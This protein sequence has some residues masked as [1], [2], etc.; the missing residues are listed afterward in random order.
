[1]AKTRLAAML[2]RAYR[3]HRAAKD[4][5]VPVDEVAA[6]DREARAKSALSRRAFLGATA[7]FAAIPLVGCEV[8]A[9]PSPPTGDQTIAI[10]GGGM[11]GL[12]CAY[13]LKQAGVRATIYEASKRSG[14]RMYSDRDTFA[15]PDGMHC[16]LGGELIDT[17][18]DTM[19]ALAKEF[20][21]E[22]L[23]YTNDDASLGELFYFGG[24]L[25]SETEILKQFKPIADA[26]DTAVATLKDPNSGVTYDA[27][28]GGEKL[29]AMSLKDFLDSAN[30]TGTIR[31]LLEISYI[32]E[33]GLE[34]DACNALN[35][36]LLISTDTTKL[37][38]FGD[39]DEL[40]HTKNGNDTF[41]QKLAAGLDADQIVL[42][43]ALTALSKSA[44]GRYL[45]SFDQAGKATD[46]TADHV[47]LALPFSIL[48]GLDVKIEWPALKKTAIAEQGMGQNA[49]LMCGFSDRV[50]RAA[51]KCN[52]GTYSDTGYQN[53][54]ETSRLQ[55]GKSGIL[56]NFT[57]GKPAIDIGAGKPEDRMAD[58][59][60][61]FDK[62]VP[63]G[64]A[65]SNGKVARYH[66][67]SSP[68]QKGSYS[69]YL[70]SQYTK[71][72]GVEIERFENIHFCGEH[73]SL[74][75]QGYM[76]GAAATGALA[77]AE[78]LKDLGK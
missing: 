75:A 65:A 52:G 8:K 29:D 46:V 67:P 17:G 7:G 43:T 28:N 49:K 38:L 66:W 73:T 60:T 32:I 78:V 6:M 50:W 42:Q 31:Q 44:D 9:N 56:T 18:H 36:L 61:Q 48:R 62:V 35:F 5:G 22:L 11:A 45:L 71:F 70:V 39:S 1:M 59:L 21:I 72:A 23:D 27:P 74:E 40:F 57:G 76:E 14:G 3:L 2:Q 37:A 10:V 63:G 58:F 41:T 20:G 51:L 53:T 24:A 19:H 68:F 30:A 33:F 54:W 15:Q 13:R 77:A 55:P 26:I 69:S 12:H 34:V 16:E 25:V 47:V 64:K 4:M